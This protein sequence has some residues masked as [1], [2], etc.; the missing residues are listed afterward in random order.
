MISSHKQNAKSLHLNSH[1]TKVKNVGT[2]CIFITKGNG[3]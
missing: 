2:D 1:E 3:I